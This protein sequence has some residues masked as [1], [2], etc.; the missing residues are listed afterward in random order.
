MSGFGLK[1][2]RGNGGAKR[3]AVYISSIGNSIHPFDNK[4]V[5]GSGVGATNIS[6]RRAKA[7]KANINTSNSVYSFRGLF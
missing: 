7:V 3:I 5:V 4:F 2:H 6:V 1:Y